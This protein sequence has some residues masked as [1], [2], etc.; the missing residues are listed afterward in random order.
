MSAGETAEDHVPTVQVGDRRAERDAPTT[1]VA[2]AT[3]QPLDAE[4]AAV[5][6]YRLKGLIGSGGFGAVYV[7]RAPGGQPVAVKLLT[8]V[9]DGARERFAREAELLHRLGGA[10]FPRYLDGDLRAARPWFAM[11]LLEGVTV[12]DAV[13]HVGPL[14]EETVVTAA[15]DAAR[16]LGRLHD[17]GYV[18]RDVK[19]ANA[20]LAGRRATLIDVGIAKGEHVHDLTTTGEMIGSVA[21]AAPERLAGDRG[22]TASDV[23][24]IGLLI[25]FASSGAMPFPRGDDAA[26]MS[27]VAE[28]RS[29]LSGVP[30]ALLPLVRRTT[31]VAPEARP[32]MREVVAELQRMAPGALTPQRPT[33]TPEV[34]SPTRVASAVAPTPRPVPEPPA[35]S[36]PAPQTVAVPQPTPPA[37]PPDGLQRMFDNRHLALALKAAHERGYDATAVHLVARAQRRTHRKAVRALDPARVKASIWRR[38]GWWD[39]QYAGRR[40]FPDTEQGW[41]QERAMVR[42]GWWLDKAAGVLA[43][44]AFLAVVVGSLTGQDASVRAP[45]G[46]L[47]QILPVVEIGGRAIAWDLVGLL[48]AVAA[49]LY[50]AVRISRNAQRDRGV[51][52][53]QSIR[54]APGLIALGY[55]VVAAAGLLALLGVLT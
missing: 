22:T 46:W 27:A 11:E 16:S 38:N 47:R 52:A 45:F 23:Y 4:V 42:R 41:S 29:D 31:A 50:G 19:P 54:F 21:W 17:L 18:H 37:G 2:T 51:G 32:P 39:G 3:P 35:A 24:G 44:V 6:P 25:A 43:L 49:A 36:P 15:L 55:A 33:R 8:Y 28:G 12:A 7:G 34:P 40:R 48:I 1:R 20:V 53:P 9:G 10:G 5:G 13:R 14:S 30:D 26:T